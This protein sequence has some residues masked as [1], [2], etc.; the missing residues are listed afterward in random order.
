MRRAALLAWVLVLGTAIPAVT[1]AFVPSGFRV[2]LPV[3]YE[4]NTASSEELGQQTTLAVIEASY[5]NWATNEPNGAAW[6][7]SASKDIII[8]TPVY[9]EAAQDQWFTRLCACTTVRVKC[10]FGPSVLK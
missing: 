1:Y 4:V 7:S 9:Q 10:V 8:L 3:R 2:D 5:E 6:M